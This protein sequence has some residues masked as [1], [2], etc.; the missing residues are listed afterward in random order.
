MKITLRA[1]LS[2]VFCS[3]F[4]ALAV[5]AFA[6]EKPAFNEKAVGDFYKGKTVRIIV[7]FSAGGGY[8]LYSRLIARYLGKYIPG[9]PNVI[10]E[11]MAGAGSILA[12]NNVANAAPKDGTVVGNISGPIIL[13]QLFGT[14]AVQFD[15][16]KLRY[17]AVPV[18]ETY[19]LIVSKKPGVSRF[20]DILGPKGKQVVLGGIPGSTVEHAP[21]IVRDVLGANIKLVA[22]YKGT[23]DVRLAIDSGE[24]DGFF[25]TWTSS[26]VTSM[27]KFKTG[28]WTILAQMG[29]EPLPDLPAAHVPTIPMLAKNEEQKQ[30]LRFG[31]SV[32]NQFGKVYLLATGVPADRATALEVAFAK[33]LADKELLAEAEKGRL[34]IKPLSAQRTQKL[35]TEFLSMSPELKAKLQKLIHPSK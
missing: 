8:D 15:M 5:G 2:A 33:A 35:V 1:M 14:P 4:V 34:E 18:E 27:D 26:K 19:L 21:I 17:L 28:E 9:T 12:A 31:T 6:A 32:P 23:A 25:N 22:G 24:V 3:A 10:V 13:E 20:E 16:A 11:N 30:L 7:G 29:D